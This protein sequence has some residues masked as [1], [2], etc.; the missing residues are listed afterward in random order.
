MAVRN[1]FS[2]LS[3]LSFWGLGFYF[4]VA[5]LHTERYS[6]LGSPYLER[7]PRLFQELHS[8]FYSTVVVYPFLITSE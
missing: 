4:A 7:W 1:L 6:R 8:V 3:G 2:Y 5:T